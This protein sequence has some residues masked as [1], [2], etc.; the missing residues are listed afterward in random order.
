MELGLYDCGPHVEEFDY[1]V[2]SLCFYLAY[3]FVDTYL[4]TTKFPEHF[5]LLEGMIHHVLTGL[6]AFSS[7]ITGN[8]F[9]MCATFIAEVPTIIMTLRHFISIPKWLFPFLFVSFRIVL[10]GYMVHLSFGQGQ[11]GWTWVILYIIFTLVN[12]HWFTKMI[13]KVN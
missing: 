5:R 6:V 4:G 11:I 12:L 1:R 13:L 9:P 8:T 2:H 3:V 10:L 7:I